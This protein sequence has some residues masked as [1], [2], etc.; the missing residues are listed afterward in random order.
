MYK[1]QGFK[2]DSLIMFQ[3]HI[4]LNEGL[5]KMKIEHFKTKCERI[6]RADLLSVLKQYEIYLI[7][8]EHAFQDSFYKE[9]QWAK[10][11][12]PIPEDTEDI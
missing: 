8:K 2:E 11:M 12:Y 5:I 1:E 6:A 4:T 3:K 7:S 10:S 9:K